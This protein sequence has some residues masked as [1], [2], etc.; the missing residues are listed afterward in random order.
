MLEVLRDRTWGPATQIGRQQDTW[1]RSPSVV[2]V[3]AVSVDY[4][5]LAS[6]RGSPTSCMFLTWCL[7]RDQGVEGKG[8][9]PRREPS[10]LA[11]G[12]HVLAFIMPC[13]DCLSS[14]LCPAETQVG[15]SIHSPCN[16]TTWT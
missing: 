10:R 7:A 14:S 4:Q 3:L 5:H 16:F 6:H 12:E 11:S 15:M 8:T 2:E 13:F 1:G 9:L